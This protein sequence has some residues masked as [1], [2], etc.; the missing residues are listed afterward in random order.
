MGYLPTNPSEASQKI[1][2]IAAAVGY[3]LELDVKTLLM[4][5][6]HALV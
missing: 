2:V 6:A 3:P 5:T 4:K 1:Q